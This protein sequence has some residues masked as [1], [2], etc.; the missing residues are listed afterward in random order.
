MALAAFET[1]DVDYRL[2]AVHRHELIRVGLVVLE[3]MAT[4]VAANAER[5][6]A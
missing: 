2:D 3:L 6:V 4:A 5:K 1:H